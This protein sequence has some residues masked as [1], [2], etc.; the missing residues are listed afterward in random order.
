MNGSGPDA[1][2]F[3]CFEDARAG[4]QLLTDT[5]DD[6]LAHRTAT[7]PL[8]L[9]SCTSEARIHRLRIIDLSNSA[10]APVIWNSKRPVG[11]VVS[12]FC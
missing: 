1:E 11:V 5:L 4:R 7:E 9:C 12:M 3:S 6:S 10:N 2:C 8:P